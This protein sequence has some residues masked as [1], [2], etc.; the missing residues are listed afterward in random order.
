MKN[1]Q[2]P[3]SPNEK[4]GILLPVLAH[5]DCRGVVGIAEIIGNAIY[6]L[7]QAVLLNLEYPFDR[8]YTDSY[9]SDC[10]SQILP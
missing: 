8:F 10:I 6:H 7:Q 4:V 9:Q 2:H 3:L 5:Y 1:K